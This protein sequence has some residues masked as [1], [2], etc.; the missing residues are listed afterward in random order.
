V[1]EKILGVC[2]QLPLQLVQV[3]IMLAVVAVVLTIPQVR[4]A[5][6][7]AVQQCLAVLPHLELQIL[8]VAVAVEIPLALV[9]QVL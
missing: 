3:V 8:A 7:E 1:L 5:Q 2:G 4:V 6:V 9:V